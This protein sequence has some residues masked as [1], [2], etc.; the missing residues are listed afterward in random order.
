MEHGWHW[1]RGLSQ[2]ILL[3]KSVFN[4]CYPRH[5]RSIFYSANE[6]N[7]SDIRCKLFFFFIRTICSSST[8][9]NA[10][11]GQNFTHSGSPPQKLHFTANPFFLLN[12]IPPIGH[13]NKHILHPW[14]R[15]LSTSQ[16]PVSRLREIAPNGQVCAHIGSSHWVQFKGKKTPCLCC[17][18]T[19]IRARDGAK[20]FSWLNEQANSQS[21]QPVHLSGLIKMYINS[22]LIRKTGKNRIMN[23]EH[24]MPNIVIKNYFSLLLAVLM[25]VTKI[26]I[27]S[28]HSFNSLFN[29][30]N[31]FTSGFRFI[32]FNVISVSLNSFNAIFI[33]WIKSFRDSALCASP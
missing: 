20:I 6:A 16:V 10:P 19:L 7:T 5:P 11:V 17:L 8:I 29:F 1:L 3:C 30:S 9:S 4:L 31:C 27:S 21:P 28:L 23:I 15:L 25:L 26:A 18:N 14:H 33:L 32:I 13:T 12:P 2:I 24:R 22:S